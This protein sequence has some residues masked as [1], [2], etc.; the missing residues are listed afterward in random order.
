MGLLLADVVLLLAGLL[1]GLLTGAM[2]RLGGLYWI[3]AAL[4][5]GACGIGIGL[6]LFAD[7]IPW[8][9]LLTLSFA[10]GCATVLYRVFLPAHEARRLPARRPLVPQPIRRALVVP[11][12]EIR[13]LG[14]LP[15]TAAR[16]AL[17]RYRL[18]LTRP[19]SPPKVS[20]A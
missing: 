18:P 4:I 20:A 12:R 7:E 1:M 6:A 5:S 2:L 13:R 19:P 3:A 9:W 11:G 10:A 15:R 16:S 8:A 17:M 14:V